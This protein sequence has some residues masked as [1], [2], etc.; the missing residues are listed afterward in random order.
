MDEVEKK[1]DCQTGTK[2]LPLNSLS[3]SYSP[4]RCPL[5]S[6]SPFCKSTISPSVKSMKVAVALFSFQSLTP[7]L[8][9]SLSND[10][11]EPSVDWSPCLSL[12]PPRS[13]SFSLLLR[14]FCL[15]IN[16]AFPGENKREKEKERKKKKAGGERAR[17]RVCPKMSRSEKEKETRREGKTEGRGAGRSG[18]WVK[19]SLG[20]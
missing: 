7:S 10:L 8:I 6:L 20:Y 4:S 2:S 3:L 19:S 16:P 17:V 14:A 9:H 15:S 13:L 12:P 1:E 5:L 18:V 11:P